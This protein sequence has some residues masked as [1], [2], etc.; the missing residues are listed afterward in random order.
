MKLTIKKNDIIS[1]ISKVQN[2]VEKKATMPVLINVLLKAK[3]DKL[4]IFA[5]DLEVSLTDESPCDIKEE[6]E[7]AVNAKYFFEVI[8]C[9]DDEGVINLEVISDSRIRVKQK[10]SVF[11]IAYIKASDYPVFPTFEAEI[12]KEISSELLTEMINSTIYCVSNDETRYHLNGVF[13]DSK[14]NKNKSQFRMVSTDGHR[15]SFIDR[16]VDLGMTPGVIVPQKGLIEVRKIIETLNTTVQIAIEGPQFIFKIGE[17][18][19]MIRLIEGRYPDY[20]KLIPEKTLKGEEKSLTIDRNLFLNSIKRV[21]LFSDQNSKEVTFNFYKGKMEIKSNNPD[22]GDATEELDVNY[23]GEYL[24]IG[25]NVRY[26]LDVINSFSSEKIKLFFK[27]SES[28]AIIQPENDK[29]YTSII[30][31]IHLK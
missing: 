13:F 26:V 22:I 27:N 23:S 2:I 15:L 10:K 20:N 19:V 18:R 3:K 24:K 16:P 25:L 5:T 29:N 30:M 6:G 28:A 14:K 8:R 4:Q 7:L 21:S 17:T 1:L 12:F 9:L 11:N 31:P